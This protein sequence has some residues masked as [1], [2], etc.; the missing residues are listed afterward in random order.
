[1]SAVGPLL[2]VYG[3][4]RRGESGFDELGLKDKLRFVSACQIRGKLYDL[5]EYPGLVLGDGVVEAELYELV[6]RQ[7]IVI[8][9]EFEC[10]DANNRADSEY[11][12]E[13]VQLIKPDIK[14]WVYV[15]N[16][17]RDGIS[18]DRSSEV[19]RGD[20]LRHRQSKVI[21]Q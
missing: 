18:I 7:A 8:L 9:D 14:A 16:V 4:L 5:G 1:M 17:E 2:A 3:S 20:W 21:S 15:Y 19:Q 6:D 13:C 11:I 12:R 10:F